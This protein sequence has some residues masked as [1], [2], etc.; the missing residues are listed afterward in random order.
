[1][2]MGS[3]RRLEAGTPPRVGR[4]VRPIGFASGQAGWPRTLHRL[5]ARSAPGGIVG[6]V[7]AAYLSVGSAHASVMAGG[8]TVTRD[9]DP[10][11]IGQEIDRVLRS[12]G[13]QR[14]L[15]AAR[16]VAR[17]PEVVGP[18]VA[19]HCQ[20]R[21]LEDDGTLFVVAD[22]AA[23]ATQLSY[24]QGTLLDRL[25][26]ILGPGIVKQVRVRTDDARSRGRSSRVGY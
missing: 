16:L 7:C 20:P 12:K 1:M 9:R 26:S 11:P 6:S 17:W 10:S 24:L 21:R 19:N 22:S 5:W 23:W 14:R 2:G 13:W 8:L 18:T 4:V 3:P 25:A 15:I